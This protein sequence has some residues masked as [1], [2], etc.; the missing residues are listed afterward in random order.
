MN[1]IQQVTLPFYCMQYHSVIPTPDLLCTPT[2]WTDILIFYLANYAAHA[3][4]TR[5]LPS[6]RNSSAAM[7]VMTALF[8]PAAGAFR[9][10][11]G[12]V[13]LE[14]FRSSDLEKAV[15]AGALCMVTR[16]PEWKPRAGDELD[17][18][19][20]RLPLL[21]SSSKNR[22]IDKSG[23]A[24]PVPASLQEEDSIGTNTTEPIQKTI[25]LAMY[26]PPWREPAL[27]CMLEDDLS[28]SRFRI[29]GSYKQTVQSVSG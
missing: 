21:E 1:K 18:T 12:I 29:H 26:D 6:E 27:Q 10:I 7:T 13:S 8:F 14:I 4:T 28:E 2:R 24:G 17:N 25:R 15:R 16:T 19:I 23:P 3:I 22:N 11:L 5:S 20:L 9:G